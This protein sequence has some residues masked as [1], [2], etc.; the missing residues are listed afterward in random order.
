M[1]RQSPPSP[2]GHPGTPDASGKKPGPGRV[3]WILDPTGKPQPVPAEP[4]ISDGTFTE[5][6]SSD[7][8]EGDSVIVA[9]KGA[10]QPSNNQQVNPFAPRFPGRR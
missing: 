9:L 1:A 8:K 5:I 3:L 10:A 2:A 6:V 4:G 7:F